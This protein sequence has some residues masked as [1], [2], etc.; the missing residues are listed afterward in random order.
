MLGF[1]ILCTTF[2]TAFSQN[3][4]TEP[5]ECR[6]GYG[7]VPVGGDFVINPGLAACLDYTSSSSKVVIRDYFAP[8]GS[9]PVPGTTKFIFNYKS[10]PPL[11]PNSPTP[12][13]GWDTTYTKPGTYWIMMRGQHTNGSDYIKC[14][15]IEVLQTPELKLD[16]DICTANTVT[17]KILPTPENQVY[18]AVS[19]DWG[20]G[21]AAQYPIPNPIP[22]TGITLTHTYIGTIV[23]PKIQGLHLRG[24]IKVCLGNGFTIPVTN[25]NI[26]KI[27]IL[28][29]LNG[30]SENKITIKGGN[31]GS[32]YNVE[33]STGGGT[34]TSTGQKIT[35]PA[36]SATASVNINGLTGTN[37][38][39][40]RLQKMGICSTPITSDPVCTIKSTYQVLTPKEVEIK[41]T[42]KSYVDPPTT[43]SIIRYQIFYRETPTNLNQN[44]VP[45]SLSA[46]PGFIFDQM[47][48]QVKYEF[49]IEGS[50]GV[51]GNRVVIKS[52]TFVVDPTTGGRL[53]S[54]LIGIA[55]INDNAVSINMFSN[56]QI[57]KYNI[58]K[59]EGNSTNFQK[60]TTTTINTYSDPAV[61]LDKQQYCY[62]VDYEDACGNTSD[63][64]DPF[65]TIFLTS[66]QSNTLNWTPF[67]VSGSPS[68]LQNV[69]PTEYT[70][71]II[72]EH[73]TVLS[74]PGNTLATEADVQASIDR[75]LNDPAM[76]GRVT[77][78]IL[79]IQDA[80]LILPSGPIAFP[81]YSYS[82]IYTFITPALLYVP[83]AFTP[84]DDTFNDVFKANG[85]FISEFNMVIYNRW[86]APIF[87]SKN[88]DI[89]WDGTDSG[90]PAPPGNYGYKIFGLDHAGQ[91]FKK[92]GSVV[93]LK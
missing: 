31:A 69:Q 85:K 50:W 23:D 15:S 82:N 30:G 24:A 42:S 78:R 86:G 75:F 77:F 10:G 80:D 43:S 84:N 14:K 19:L 93:L 46:N 53:P 66:A 9:P 57:N 25:S 21:N 74:T 87:E 44:S 27:T 90:T 70:I 7:S 45:I 62:K 89:G 60:L 16:Y 91:E 6:N 38:Y 3:V 54:A 18:N 73:G 67:S 17:I 39:C 71:Q 4:I 1:I 20:D 79:A 40:F 59:A 28:E 63:M 34:W 2:I 92:V 83:S 58:Y 47:D 37:D 61:Q 13:P 12:G 88:M 36:A 72:D 81:F 8:D 76:N 26:P 52:P 56:V 22:T 33:M 11:F 48:C 64:S 65:C 41:W 5:Q 55:S 29:G 68:V 32:D 35:A 51:G 49:W